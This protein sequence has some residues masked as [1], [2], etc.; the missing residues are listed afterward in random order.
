MAFDIRR[1]I[2]DLLE[3]RRV[4]H[5]ERDFQIAFC[6]ELLNKGY[7]A[8]PEFYFEEENGRRKYLDLVAIIDGECIAFEFKYKTKE[9][10]CEP[11]RDYITIKGEKYKLFEQGARDEGVYA[12]LS[13]VCRLERVIKKNTEF[14]DKKITKGYVVFL[15]NDK[16]YEGGF[17]KEN[18]LYFNYGLKDKKTFDTKKITFNIPK[19]KTKQDT[20]AKNKEELQ[21]NKGFDV[22]WEST[23]IDEKNTMYHLII[24]RN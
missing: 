2:K 10:D 12:V 21:L 16:G 9:C 19:G 3:K 5:N 18:C 4:F 15:T 6:F 20:N 24:E 1:F 22:H 17:T 23:K 13:D 11:D 7:M 14:L 8:R